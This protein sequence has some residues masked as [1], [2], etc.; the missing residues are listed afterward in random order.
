MERPSSSSSKN[1]Q[2]NEQDE[3]NGAVKDLSLRDFEGLNFPPNLSDFQILVEV[4]WVAIRKLEQ[5]RRERQN[6]SVLHNNGNINNAVA[7]RDQEHAEL[8][9]APRL[10]EDFQ[11]E[12]NR[13]GGTDVTLVLPNKRLFGTDVSSHHNRFSIPFGKIKH[14]PGFLT[15][16]ERDRL[17]KGESFKAVKLIDPAKDI[18]MTCEL[19]QWDMKKDN[20]SVSSMYVLKGKWHKDVVCKNKLIEGDL[21]Q[22][23][24]FRVDGAICFALVMLQRKRNL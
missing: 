18:I 4:A 21:V 5:T 22:L 17:K 7:E 20:K 14:L 3:Q 6:T 10:P 11:R 24:S 8:P 2:E 16:D 12:I 13:L 1:D 19:G 15:I 23:W 9:A